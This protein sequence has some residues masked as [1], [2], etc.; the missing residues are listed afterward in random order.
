VRLSGESTASVGLSYIGMQ[1]AR[2][3]G[4]RSLMEDIAASS[5]RADGSEGLNL[6]IGNPAVIPDVVEMWRELSRHALTTSFADAGQ[7]GP[8]R[9]SPVLVHAIAEYFRE[10]LGWVIGPENIAVGP[11]S[12]ML[13][14]AAAALY[15]GD[16]AAGFRRIGLPMV[17]EYTGY[18][19]M[20]LIPDGIAGSEAV[21]TTD[22]SRSFSYA[23]DLDA[24]ARRDDLGMLLISSPGNPTG[25]SVRQDEQDGLIAIAQGLDIPL[26]LDHAYGQPFPQVSPVYAPPVI[27]PNVVNC[28]SLSKAGLPG[29]RIGF[30]I[31]PE[32]YITPMVSFLSNSVLHAS[33]LTQATVA[34]GLRSGAID[35]AVATV[36]RP[37]YV[38]RRALAEKLLLN[39]M[40]PGVDW[41]LHSNEGGMFA[42]LWVNEDW[43]NDLTLYRDLKARGVFVT[44]GRS[45]FTAPQPGHH[46]TQC[47]R[48][49]LSV[50]EEILREGI[51]GIG[52]A[53]GRLRPRPICSAD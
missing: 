18:Q 32:R 23:L 22:G 7:Y 38:G 17:P 6:S 4:L 53:L 34:E 43:F 19:G 50:D 31:G 28:F 20:C 30:A 2:P 49:T 44:P 39:A 41:Q 46:S 52:L 9:G 51:K 21:W 36:I 5:A 47:F 48:I 14:F 8:S 1:M 12:Q 45:F 33:R 35:H 11:G 10:H 27:H 26:F 42:W 15:C 3:S 16:G 29:E 25:R 37:F 40:P 24:L 13:C